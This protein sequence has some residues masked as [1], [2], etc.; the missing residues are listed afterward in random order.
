[1]DTCAQLAAWQS[2]PNTPQEISVN[3]SPRQLDDPS[4]P[5]SVNEAL[6]KSSVAPERLCLELTESMFLG[7]GAII[8]RTVGAL[9]DLGVRIGLDDFGAGQSSLGYLR[10]F[11]LDFVKID[12]GLVSGLGA[13]QE[14]TAIIRATIELG[15]SLGLLVVAVGVENEEQLEFLRILECDRAQG[16]HFLPAVPAAEFADRVLERIR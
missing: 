14:D 12:R 9:R 10:R 1:M 5:T 6:E 7:Q 8:D 13:D 15:H 3:V 11:P 4:F 16:F 2:A